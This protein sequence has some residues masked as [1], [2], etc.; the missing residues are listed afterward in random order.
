MQDFSANGSFPAQGAKAPPP[1]V[2]IAVCGM[3]LRVPGGVRNPQ[4]LWDML[5]SKSEGRSVI[6]SDRFNVEGYYSEHQPKQGTVNFKHGY[7]LEEGLQHFDAGFFSMSRRE[8]ERLDPQQRLLLEVVHECMESAGEVGWRGKNIGCMVGSFGQ[9]WS[10]LS[11]SDKLASGLYT[12][13]GQ[14]DFLL[15]NRVSFEYDLKG[16]SLTVKTACSSAAIAFHLA[17]TALARGECDGVIVGGT[18]VFTAPGASVAMTE[19]GLVSPEGRSKPFDASADGY[20]RAEAVNSV[21][22]RRLDDALRDGGPVRAVVRG[23]AL[24]SDGKSASLASPSAEAHEQLIR[25][26]YAV[27]GLDEAD[28]PYVECH[29]TG[30]KVRQ[31]ADLRMRTQDVDNLFKIGDP[32]ETAAIASVFGNQGTYLGSVCLQTLVYS[33]H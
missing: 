11:Q 25:K 29:G 26:A 21:Y 18:S 9:D 14:G 3:A 33:S 15:A 6:P 12:I 27:A 4:E 13:T 16:P 24:N 7:F 22:L 8:V 1:Y 19:Q 5:A 28:A 31:T 23:S 2:P 20:A 32:L 30:T 10:E 17:C